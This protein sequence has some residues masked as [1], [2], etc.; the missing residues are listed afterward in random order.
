VVQPGTDNIHVVADDAGTQSGLVGH[1]RECYFSICG[2]QRS[3]NGL[4]TDIDLGYRLCHEMDFII[5]G[6]QMSQL[7][8]ATITHL[9]C[10]GALYNAQRSNE[11]MHF[12]DF[13]FVL[14]TR[15]TVRKKY[16]SQR[17]LAKWQSIYYPIYL[18]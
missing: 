16:Y 7:F 1:F 13:H 4:L 15:T 9:A 12:V 18:Y 14:C 8:N 10:R 6:S 17:C 2:K 5:D 3:D 11:I